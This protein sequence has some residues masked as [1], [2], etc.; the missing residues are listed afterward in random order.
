MWYINT[1]NCVIVLYLIRYWSRFLS[2]SFCLLPSGTNLIGKASFPLQRLHH[3]FSL[4]PHVPFLFFFVWLAN[5][6]A[7]WLVHCLLD[8]SP[9]SVNCLVDHLVW[10]ETLYF[11]NSVT[12]VNFIRAKVKGSLVQLGC[13]FNS[14]PNEPK[15]ISWISVAG[16]LTPGTDILS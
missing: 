9:H 11:E 14:A 4:S 7:G 3:Y 8:Q 13:K 1:M 10:M 6:A 15:L 5:L 12:A 2:P 16:K